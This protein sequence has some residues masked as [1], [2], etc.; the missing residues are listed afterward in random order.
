MQIQSS[1]YDNIQTTVK[2]EERSH[3]K[4][5][6]RNTFPLIASTICKELEKRPL[7]HYGSAEFDQD[8]L[9]NIV[10]TVIENLKN[11]SYLTWR[12][13]DGLSFD[14]W[15]DRIKYLILQHLKEKL[16]NLKEVKA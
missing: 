9:G 14:D 11:N 16:E 1:L 10:T 6:G 4:F 7:S 3:L 15:F 2:D 12:K 8:E 5:F 13:W